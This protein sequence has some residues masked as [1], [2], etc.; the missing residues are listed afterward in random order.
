MFEQSIM[1]LTFGFFDIKCHHFII[2]SCQTSGWSFV[3][4]LSF[5]HKKKKCFV[6]SQSVLEEE[7]SAHQPRG[8][9]YIM[10]IYLLL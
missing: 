9:I 8:T 5:G 3:I 4:F 7:L 6:G 2:L 10:Y 1:K